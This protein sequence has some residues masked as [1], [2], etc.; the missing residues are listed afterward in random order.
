MSYEVPFQ[1]GQIVK[2]HENQLGKIHEIQICEDSDIK[3]DLIW[4]FNVYLPNGNVVQNVSSFAIDVVY[5]MV[6][7]DA[8]DHILIT[9][10]EAIE[11][12][13]C[14]FFDNEEMEDEQ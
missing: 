1:L 8:F 12:N 7:C 3:G 11:D 14:Q 13:N 2:I 4:T 9:P 10:D 6:R 5:E